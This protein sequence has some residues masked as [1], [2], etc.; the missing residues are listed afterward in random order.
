MPQ[1]LLV[2]KETADFVA[3]HNLGKG[4][5]VLGINYKDDPTLRGDYSLYVQVERLG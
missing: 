5:G 2:N 3:T 1:V 4:N